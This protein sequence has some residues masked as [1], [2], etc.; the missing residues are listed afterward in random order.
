MKTIL[1]VDDDELIRKMFG[2]ALERFGFRVVVATS[3][4]EALTLA[5]QHLPDLVLSDINMPG[6]DGCTLLQSMRADPELATK[7]IVLMTGQRTETVQRSS[8]DLGADDFLLKPFSA[9]ELNR[10]VTARLRRSDVSRRV[11]DQAIHAIQKTLHST[12][13]HEFFTPLAGILGL[14]EIL[15]AD[16]SRLAPNELQE[17]LIDIQNSGLRLHRT[18]RNYLMLFD[19]ERANPQEPSIQQGLSGES[20]RESIHTGAE[21]AARRHGRL[22]HLVLEIEPCFGSGNPYDIAII[23]EELVVNACAYSRHGSKVILTLSTSGM[24]TVKDEGRGMTDDQLAQVGAFRQFN[25]ARFEQQGLGLGLALIQRL[26]ARNGATFDIQSK[27]GVGTIVSLS[28]QIHKYTNV[29]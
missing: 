19:L 2:A 18:L 17:I 4:D 27:L 23:A 21:T 11:E 15:Q 9:E 12:L 5:H 25:R 10:C 26:A 6:T 13:P 22:Q 7:Q 28:T 3:G 20:L 24:L 29:S 16:I 1:L 8:M 14:V